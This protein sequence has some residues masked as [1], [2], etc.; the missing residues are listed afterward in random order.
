VTEREASK[1]RHS[2]F[3]T[4]AAARMRRWLV[5]GLIM[6]AITFVLFALV[7]GGSSLLILVYDFTATRVELAADSSADAFDQFDPQLGWTNIPNT[8]IPDMFGAGRYIRI[9]S[10][11]LR[12]DEEIDVEV[13]PGRVRAICSGDSFTFGQGVA[14]DDTWCAL[15]E[16]RDARLQS[17]NMGQPGYGVGQAYLR[18]MRDGATLKHDLHLFAFIEADFARLGLRRHHGHPK[19]YL[20]L[21]EGKLSSDNVPIANFQIYRPWMADLG[22]AAR[23]LRVTEFTDRAF[24]DANTKEVA[25]QARIEDRRAVASALIREMKSV[26]DEMGG[27]LMLVYLPVL[28]D[29][30]RTRLPWNRWIETEAARQGIPFVDLSAALRKLPPES[31]DALFI[32]RN[33]EEYLR[34]DGHYT[35]QGNAWVAETLWIKANLGARIDAIGP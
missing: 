2:N 26:T 31:V 24:S 32:P 15:L 9:N 3:G 25:R 22:V 7:E 16:R 5:R 4:R 13:A 10:R 6:T 21:V 34:G 1:D 11:G 27:Q 20:Q 14:N 18:Y 17:V 23:S 33:S 8:H 19:P 30:R 35:E 28:E 12:N 29:A